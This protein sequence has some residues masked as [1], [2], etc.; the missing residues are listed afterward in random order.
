MEPQR[1]QYLL[2]HLLRFFENPQVDEVLVNG[3]ASL[4]L[5]IANELVSRTNPFSSATELARWAQIFARSQGVRLDPV[6]G[7]AGGSFQEGVY[8]WH[9]VLPP[10]APDGPLLCLRRHRF[11]DLQ[12]HSFQADGSLLAELQTYMAS[13]GNLLVAG[14]T[15]S[16]KTSIMAALLANHAQHE[17]VVIIESTAELPLTSA[18]AVR[19]LE[20]RPNLEQVGAVPLEL[21]L[22][23][24]LRLRPDRLVV[25]EVRGAEAGAL[26]EALLT[27]HSGVMATIH[28]SN[29]PDALVRLSLLAEGN[30][31]ASPIAGWE[32]MAISVL[33]MARGQP[34]ALQSLTHHRFVPSG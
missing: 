28:A 16:G 5:V 10:L 19:L 22:R 32:V 34:P 13:R 9:C 20:R 8:R 6:C 30:R 1:Q 14:P 7:S 31:R 24:A 33:M 25:G 15:G 21:L 26:C 27:G 18:R 29:A 23:E 4:W 3:A 17:R 12:L 11:K 2:E